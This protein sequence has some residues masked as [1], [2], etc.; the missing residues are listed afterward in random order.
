[1]L[2]L[3]FKQ[4]PPIKNL[5][6][7]NMQNKS[8]KVKS[9][10]FSVKYSY[11]V[12]YL[13]RCMRLL[14]WCAR[15]RIN[16]MNMDET[17]T[18]Q[19]FLIFPRNFNP[20]R[21]IVL[22]TIEDRNIFSCFGCEVG[23]MFISMGNVIDNQIH[24]SIKTILHLFYTNNITKRYSFISSSKYESNNKADGILYSLMKQQF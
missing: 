20:D 19:C 7:E 8:H 24:I 12:E 9:L 5:L 15:E 14:K 13:S 6:Y 3:W 17:I 10:Y 2:R 16:W 23:V 1:M 21:L 22:L 11:C 4:F 18:V